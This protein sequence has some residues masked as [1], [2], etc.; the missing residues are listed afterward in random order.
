MA[1]SPLQVYLDSSDIS[2]FAS[3]PPARTAELREIEHYLRSRQA[4]GRIQLRFSDAHV[5]EAAAT[6]REAIPAASARLA[7][8]QDLC[9]A[10]CLPHFL[11]LA[12]EEIQRTT[13]LKALPR[14]DVL[15]DDGFWFPGV[16]VTE[17][18]L[19]PEN[20]LSQFSHLGRKERREYLKDGRLTSIARQKFGLRI[21]QTLHGIAR[22][23]PLDAKSVEVWGR[24]YLEALPR[25]EAELA[26]RRSLSD[27]K[28]FAKWYEDDS[29]SAMAYSA[30]LRDIGKDFKGAL[31]AGRVDCSQLLEKAALSAISAEDVTQQVKATFNDELQRGIVDIAQSF[32]ESMGAKLDLK[33]LNGLETVCP[34]I[35]CVARLSLYVARRS[36]LGDTPREAKVS[37]FGDIYH[38]VY[39]PYVDIYRTDAFMADLIR[40]AQIPGRTITVGRLNDLPT[41][42]E[43]AL[44]NDSN[45]GVDEI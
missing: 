11:D 19:S 44:R 24:Y 38:A 45:V 39:I 20:M 21:T 26:L 25:G 32:A 36:V 18:L 9:G 16:F 6:S 29:E 42:I 27:L 35:A 40:E 33:E 12:T 10:K 7:K 14:G 43:N 22:S 34:G 5:T 41:A 17:L 30:I 2:S 3:P 8:I 4:E 28:S 15:R 1:S 37:D 13:D 23:L 31:D